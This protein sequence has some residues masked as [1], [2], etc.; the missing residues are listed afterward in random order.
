MPQVLV[1]ST[2]GPIH[3]LFYIFHRLQVLFQEQY[4]TLKTNY[5]WEKKTCSKGFKASI[6]HEI[7]GLMELTGVFIPQK[8]SNI[9][10]QKW[11][12]LVDLFILILKNIYFFIIL[13]LFKEGLTNNVLPT[14]PWESIMNFTL[15]I[16]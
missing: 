6:L 8:F 7:P 15:S 12:H 16:S 3:F 5:A 10:H 1:F 13:F 9:D 11:L 14:Q 4:F 2:K